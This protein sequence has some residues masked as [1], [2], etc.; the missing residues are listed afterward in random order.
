MN[1][2][3]SDA[4]RLSQLAPSVTIP[5]SPAPDTSNSVQTSGR[6][7]PPRTSRR[8]APY[9]RKK[10]TTKG[11]GGGR[12]LHFSDEE[13][14]ILLDVLEA[15]PPMGGIGWVAVTESYNHECQLC[16]IDIF[17]DEDSLQRRFHNVR[18][19]STLYHHGVI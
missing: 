16:S 9:T 10:R 4:F 2:F 13:T 12:N 3:V 11:E 18:H 1:I 15:R 17:R 8:S 19:V 7:R 14:E 6:D 5:H